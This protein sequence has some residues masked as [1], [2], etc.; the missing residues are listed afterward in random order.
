MLFVAEYELD[1]DDLEMAAAKRMEW[2]E[3]MPETFRFVGEYVWHNGAPPFRGIAIFEVGEADDVHAFVLHYGATM[4]MRI[5][6]ATDVMSALGAVQG[7]AE[8]APAA[9]QAPRRRKTKKS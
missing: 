5:S 4:S 6:P 1:W 9:K 2:Q 7:R 8:A 3:V